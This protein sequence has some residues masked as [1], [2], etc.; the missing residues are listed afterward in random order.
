[1]P[2]NRAGGILIL[3]NKVLLI[4]R[5]KDKEEFYVFPG[6]GLEI[7]ETPTQAVIREWKEELQCDITLSNQQPIEIQ[8]T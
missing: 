2:K 4:H 1:M 3:N 7:N 8:I 5:I 6:G